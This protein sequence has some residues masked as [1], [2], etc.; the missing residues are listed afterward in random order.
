[1]TPGQSYAAAA[2]V[3]ILLAVAG[4]AL[5]YHRSAR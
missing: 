1:M 3:V 2:I 5:W 4:F